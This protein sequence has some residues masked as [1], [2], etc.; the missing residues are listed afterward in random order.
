LAKNHSKAEI[1]GINGRKIVEKQFNWKNE[2]NSY[3]KFYKKV[4]KNSN[5]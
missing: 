3:L 4:L 5:K 1:M 2:A